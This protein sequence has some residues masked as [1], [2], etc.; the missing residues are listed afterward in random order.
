MYSRAKEKPTQAG[1]KEDSAR[2]NG[3][4]NASDVLGG[5]RPYL[6]RHLWGRPTRIFGKVSNQKLKVKQGPG[7]DSA[8]KR[9]LLPNLCVSPGTHTVE[10]ENY[11]PQVVCRSLDAHHP[12]NVLPNTVEQAHT[13]KHN[14]HLH[15]NKWV[16]YNFKNW[17][18]QNVPLTYP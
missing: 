10:G 5:W 17:V 8:R 16:K 15:I 4:H 18:K 9:Y 12:I 6:D 2:R 13:H 3:T 1:K 11:Q 7:R 14:A